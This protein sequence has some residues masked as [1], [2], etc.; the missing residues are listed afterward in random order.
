[1]IEFVSEIFG[2]NAFFH[3]DHHAKDFAYKFNQNISEFKDG[4]TYIESAV[5]YDILTENRNITPMGEYKLKVILLC[6]FLI[7][8]IIGVIGNFWLQT[9]QRA[10]EVAIM[11]SFGAVQKKR[12]EEV[13]EVSVSFV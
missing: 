13:D 11:K 12:T 6:F 7:N 10:S 3:F 8:L 9:R 1:M 5:T 4:R 2:I